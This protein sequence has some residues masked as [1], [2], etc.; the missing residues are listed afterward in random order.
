MQAVPLPYHPGVMRPAFTPALGGLDRSLMQ[1]SFPSKQPIASR[2][3]LS[4]YLILLICNVAYK[5]TKSRQSYYIS[6]LKSDESL[7]TYQ[8]LLEY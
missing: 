8:K 6:K 5:D 7:N 1:L 2:A 4:I 3:L